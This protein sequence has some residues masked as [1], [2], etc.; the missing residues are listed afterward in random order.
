MYLT[1]IRITLVISGLVH[2]G[3]AALLQPDFMALDMPSE[4]GEKVMNITFVGI[5]QAQP[6][7][8]EIKETVEEVTASEPEVEEEKAEDEQPEEVQETEQP[9][10]AV[11]TEV[12]DPKTVTPIKPLKKKKPPIQKN[13]IAKPVPVVRVQEREEIETE[14][15]AH[16][17][18][19][20]A[21][22]LVEKEVL[23]IQGINHD[24]EE[25]RLKSEYL[26]SLIKHIN[27]K[28]F[29]PRKARKRRDEGQVMIAFTIQKS[30]DFTR[31]RITGSSG[32]GILDKAALKTIKRLSPFEPLPERVG[33]DRWELVVPISFTLRD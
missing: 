5:R 28:K 15:V 24:P 12:S 31:V 13:K 10:K 3:A 30:G 20:N 6:P 7:V 27:R 33:M 19:A 2:L 21:L 29:Y 25:D 22:T 23:P 4:S 26:T 11:V 8:T 1:P 17:H 14:E 9:E 32:S 16:N 18:V